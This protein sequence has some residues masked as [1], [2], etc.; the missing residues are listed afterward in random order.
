MNKNHPL[1][2]TRNAREKPWKKPRQ[3]SRCLISSSRLTS[4]GA[5][6]PFLL[7]GKAHKPGDLLRSSPELCLCAS[8]SQHR[9]ARAAQS[10]NYIPRS[11]EVQ[12][13][14]RNR[15]PPCFPLGE[16]KQGSS[17]ARCTPR[18]ILPRP[19][20][21]AKMKFVLAA[22][23]LLLLLFGLCAHSMYR[24]NPSILISYTPVLCWANV[25]FQ[26]GLRA[27]SR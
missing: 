27:R 3:S 9:H 13:T 17:A 6:H 22:V 2:I 20:P 23:S 21:F 1:S 11:E 7:H 18:P 26:K 14:F 24:A 15:C 10:F 4:S 12:A 5:P 8:L 25:E 16:I 19:H